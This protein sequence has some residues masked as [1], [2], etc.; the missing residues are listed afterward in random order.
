MRTEGVILIHREKAV[1]VYVDA[2]KLA[3]PRLRQNRLARRRHGHNHTGLRT[4]LGGLKP[5]TPRSLTRLDGTTPAALATSDRSRFQR[6]G[7]SYGGRRH[8]AQ[9]SSPTLGK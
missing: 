1:D 6:P 3:A 8:G 5:A 4:S 9:T 2:T 7:L